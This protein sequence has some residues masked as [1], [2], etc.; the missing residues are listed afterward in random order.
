MAEYASRISTYTTGDV[1]EASH[2]NDEF[3]AILAAFNA[4]TGHKHDS[5]AG[6]GSYVPLIA[7]SDANNKISSDSA[8]NRFGV[9]VEVSSAPV[10]QFRFQD[11]AI[12]PVTD[13]D[14]DLGTASLE[15]KDAYFDGTI[16]VDTLVIGSATGVTD[17]DTD[18]SSVSASHDTLASAK[19]IKTYVDALS[20]V[21]ASIATFLGTPS[22]ANLAAAVTDE[23]GSGLLV[24]GTS[25]T[26]TTPVISSIVNTGTLTLPTSTDTLVGRATSDTLTNKTLTS[27]VIST[28]VNTGTLT[29]PTST[30]TL[31]GKATTD[32][33]TNKTFDANGTGNSITNLEVADF[34]SGVIDTD[35]SSVSGSDDTLASAKAIKSYVDSQV[36]TGINIDALTDGTGITLASTDLLVVS[37]A[38]TEK[39]IYVS[40]LD[41][42]V[43]SSSQTLT[44]KTIDAS[45]L[46]GTVANA[47]LDSELQ[48]LAGLASAADKL[49]Y[50]TGSGT[51]SLADFTS[52]GRSLV[53]D[54]DSTAARSTLGLVIGTN[55]QAYD[56]ELAAIAGL[57]SAADKG[58]QFTG[59]GTAA[60]FDLTTAGKALL[61]D[62]DAS[63][64]RTT[65][66]LGTV[67]T[68]NVGTSANNIVQLDGSAKLPAVDGSQLTGLTGA[69]QGFALAVAVAL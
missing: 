51:A 27:P 3:N 56:A 47:R 7:D 55:V 44:N 25:P 28:I 21:N 11:G 60:T 41:S 9:F 22:S 6:G 38:G 65:L 16:N 33:F 1:I 57:T 50:F 53:D 34:A 24:F 5:T 46:S 52:F 29:L 59:S 66:G 17:V 26:L 10:E 2:T 62:A 61:D 49:P 4:S 69:S 8:S 31:V 58:I 23:T 63:A 19:A 67:A 18:L 40:Q 37:D 15:F 20:Y 45:Q 39:K 42:Y 48:A 35:L 14:I 43:S 30:D 12:V 32:T 36:A 54:A 68:L 64:Q 13:N